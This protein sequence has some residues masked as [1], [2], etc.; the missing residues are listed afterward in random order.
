[1]QTTLTRRGVAVLVFAVAALAAG[2]LFG[3]R[4]LNAVAVPLFVVL[5][6]AFVYVRR[7]DRP[8]V[9]RRVPETVRRGDS[10]VLS[11]SVEQS[12]EPTVSVVDP[13]D[14]I[15]GA[16]TLETVADGREA[17][18]A[19]TFDERGEHT[20]GPTLVTASDPLGLWT[21]SFS[22]R[23][24]GT[25][26]VQPRVHRLHETASLL[27]GYVGLTDERGQFDSLREYRAGDSLR[28]VNWRVSAKRDGDLVVTTYAGE[29]AT[30]AVTIAVSA[31]GP[32]VDSA[33]EAA[34]SI[35]VFCLDHGVDVAL[36]TPTTRLSAARGDDHRRRVLDALARFDGGTVRRD[37]TDP[38]D[39]AVN[40]PAD[41]GH[42]TVTA[43]GMTRRYGEVVGAPDETTDSS[44]VAA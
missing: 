6:G 9:Y 35:A 15:R 1:M 28:D 44:E 39:V 37:P 27:A 26:L 25:V 43:A 14:G 42:V 33:A 16:S 21:R 31:D 32:R 38:A 3:G 34:A 20:V 13:L 12:G 22:V 36:H 7:L 19:V 18:R 24:E 23:N 41:G 4:T 8:S 30:N 11:L 10:H 40:A 17:T 2:W 5:A 29:G